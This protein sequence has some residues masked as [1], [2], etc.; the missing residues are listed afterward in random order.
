MDLDVDTKMSARDGFSTSTTVLSA[1]NRFPAILDVSIQLSQLLV[2]AP[3]FAPRPPLRRLI[4]SAIII[5]LLAAPV[6]CQTAVLTRSYNN[7]RTAANTSETVLTPD[8]VLSQRTPLRISLNIATKDSCPAD[9]PADQRPPGATRV[10]AQPLYVPNIRMSDGKK[11]DVIYAFSMENRVWA[12][13]ANTGKAIWPAPVFLGPPF[14]PKLN[15]AVDSKGINK[16]FGILST[17]VI[18]LDA[19]AMYVVN[20]VTDDVAHQ[21]RILQVNALRLSDGWP[22]PGKEM[23]LAIEASA[24]N[25]SGEQISLNQ[26]QKQR[27]ALLLVPLRTSQSTTHKILYV[28][29]TGQ[30]TP[31]SSENAKDALHGWVVAFDVRVWKQTASWTST[32]NSFGGGIWQASQGPAAD[33]DRHV[34]VVTSNGGYL[35]VN[36]R[37]KNFGIGTTDFPESFVKLSY[38]NN[39]RGATLVPTD[40]FVAFPDSARKSWNADEVKPFPI[41]YDY[42]DEDLGSAGPVLPPGTGL[43]LGAGKDGVLYVLSTSNMGKATWDCTKL[44]VPPLFFTYDPDPKLLGFDPKTTPCSIMPPPVMNPPSPNI[45]D[46]KPTAGLKTHHL[47]GS[48]VYWVSSKR[49][50]MLF[51][52]GENGVLRAFSFRKSGGMQLLA[53]SVDVASKD[54]ALDRATLGGMPGGMLTLSSDQ[55]ENGIIWATAPLNGDANAE[56]VA[57]VV[58]AYDASN[59]V[60]VNG[61][62]K[63]RKLW[64]ATGFTYSKFCPP[65]VADGR[66][67]VPTYDGR[68]DVYFFT[69]S[70]T[71]ETTHESARP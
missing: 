68:I 23:P 58:R 6:F 34:Y 14:C 48:P 22:V 20:W 25:A 10:E 51:G 27:A 55:Q 36:G 21:H 28:A 12:F 26:V 45:L 33:D 15:D 64:E 46:F 60:D 59:F 39:S 3:H 52:W 8:L 17:P 70:Q 24:T 32:P 66:L 37:N 65:I 43:I 18:D 54:L 16:S 56:A 50:P 4:G 61:S 53:E 9:G 67:I 35:L 13:D 63:L 7:A 41:G 5:F 62:P 40:W 69:K 44:Q 31:P 71:H 47:H 30:E 57:G 42:T 49:G 11:H 19:G 38:S 1:D 29:F 2:V